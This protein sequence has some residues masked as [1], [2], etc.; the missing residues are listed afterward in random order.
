MWVAATFMAIIAVVGLVVDGGAKIRAGERADLVAGEASRAASYANGP[1]NI[2]RTSAAVAAARNVLT[3]SGLT[4]SV[5]VTGPGRVDIAVQAN[6]T[7]P[8][9][10][11]T[12]TVTRSAETQILLGVRT[13]DTP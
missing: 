2:T 5:T 12:Y 3:Q 7:G 11:A 9:S 10:G 1:D 4:G 8:I 6:A 13:G